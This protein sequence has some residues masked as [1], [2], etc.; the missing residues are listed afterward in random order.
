MDKFDNGEDSNI[1]YIFKGYSYEQ[2]RLP[3]NIILNKIE[4][5]FLNYI[6]VNKNLNKSKFK[7]P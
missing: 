7:R 3:S 2:F 5:N 4:Y 1:D 6:K